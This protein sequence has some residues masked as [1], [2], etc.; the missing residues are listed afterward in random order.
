MAITDTQK[1]DFLW[2]KIGFGVTKTDTATAKSGTNEKYASAVPTYAH[3]IWAQASSIPTTPP[4]SSTSVV[5]VRTGASAVTATHDATSTAGRTWVTG[6]NDW[7]PDTFGATPNQYAVKVWVTSVGGTR[8]YPDGSGSDDQWYFDYVSGILH[9]IGPNLPTGINASSII[10]I[11]GYTY[12]GNKG[13]VGAGA[14][15]STKFFADISARDVDTAVVAGDLAL[16]ADNGDGEYAVYIANADGPTNNWTL[17]S[18]KDSSETDAKT[19]T[20]T[21]DVNSA[22]PLTLGNISGT[23]RP[24]SVVVEVITPFTAIGGTASSAVLAIGDA[25]SVDRL[26]SGTENDLTE[27]GSY[28]VV[29]TYVYPSSTTDTDLLATLTVGDAISGLATLTVTFA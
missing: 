15:S 22:S 27:V 8:L 14:G 29:P 6:I 25:V 17:I 21:V 20:A 12:K 19:L 26:M 24:V 23:K 7:I 4:A 5:E 11:E 28:M 18:T 10:K 16:V 13:L 1:V 2:K 3:D 9:F